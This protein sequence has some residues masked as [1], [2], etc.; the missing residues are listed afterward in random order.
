MSIKSLTRSERD[1][2]P[3]AEERRQHKR[4]P[5]YWTGRLCKFNGHES[6]V[7]VNLMDISA[8][9]ARVTMAEP[10]VGRP[11][12]KL[13]IDRVGEFFGEV[14]WEGLGDLGIRFIDPDAGPASAP[15]GDAD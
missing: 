6:E 10:L 1:T 3:T 7:S 14:V 5:V 4:L 11:L 9:G 13:T 8:G 2:E 12:V 15:T